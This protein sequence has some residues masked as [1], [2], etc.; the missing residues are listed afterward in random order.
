VHLAGDMTAGREVSASGVAMANSTAVT[1]TSTTTTNIGLANLAMKCL[2]AKLDKSEQCRYSLSTF[3]LGCVGPYSRTS[4]FS[5]WDQRPLSEAQ[6]RCELTPPHALQRESANSNPPTRC[7]L[8]S[9]SH[10]K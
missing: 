4:S 1:N 6:I 5:A 2:G 10:Q 9:K 8:P 3:A 7:S